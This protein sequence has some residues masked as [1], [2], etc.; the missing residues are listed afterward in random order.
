MKDF[1]ELYAAISSTV[2]FDSKWKNATGYYDHAVTAD[3]GLRPGEMA[4]F[5][6][7]LPSGRRG[8]IGGTRF[9]NT[10]VFERYSPEGEVRCEVIVGNYP[11]EVRGFFGGNCG[12]GDRLNGEGLEFICGSAD[13]VKY[14]FNPTIGKRI[15]NML[16]HQLKE[17]E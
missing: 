16:S 13:W 15:E 12:I 14:S 11:D 17:N 2:A 9:G 4:K 5:E 8:I 10:V 7:P 6:E 1:Q 3:I